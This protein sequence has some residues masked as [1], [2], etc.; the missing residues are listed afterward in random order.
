M[1]FGTSY[2]AVPTNVC[3][4]MR[5]RER[6]REGERERERERESRQNTLQELLEVMQAKE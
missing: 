6:E 5:E 3:K 1:G 4:V 2:R